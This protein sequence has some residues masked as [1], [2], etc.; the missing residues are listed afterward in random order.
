MAALAILAG[1]LLGSLNFAILIA[2]LRGK[3]DIRKSGTHNPGAANV[4]R[5]VGRGWGL[6]V[7]LLDAS[8]S[9]LPMLLG[10]VLLFTDTGAADTW[11][12]F[13]VG[14]A[15]VIGHCFPLYHRFRGGGGLSTTLG[16]FLFMIPVEYVAALLLAGIL[17]MTALRK[18]PYRFGRWTPIVSVALAPILV[19]AANSAPAV[20]LFAHVSIGGHPP[21]VV[22]GVI[23]SAAVVLGILIGK[24]RGY[25]VALRPAAGPPG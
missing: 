6:L 23:V 25:D 24:A 22:A 15:A 4:F 1:Y 14:L 18:V 10:R 5:S 16:L 19:V 12:L 8:K 2:R 7:G 21:W 11:A 3:G 13:A 17:A 20:P 9:F